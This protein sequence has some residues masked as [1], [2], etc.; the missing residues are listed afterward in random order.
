G[1]HHEERD[2]RRFFMD[3]LLARECA[4]FL[5]FD[6]DDAVGFVNLYPK[7]ASTT[8]RR[9]WILNDLFVD[10]DHR[11]TGVAHALMQRAEDHA[12]ATG[13]RVITLKTHV[14]N[15]PAQALYASRNWKAGDE[16]LTYTKA[17][18]S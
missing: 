16:F 9:Y 8:L 7:Y 3:R 14:T 1:T 2:V 6:R 11:R 17:F 4:A 18:S 13:A 12:R 15:A 10:E 5:A